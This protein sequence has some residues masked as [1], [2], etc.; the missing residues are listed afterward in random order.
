MDK[1]PLLDT[2]TT[3]VSSTLRFT[4]SLLLVCFEDK[5][6]C[7]WSSLSIPSVMLQSSVFRLR[8]IF[9]P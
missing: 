6:S 1:I 4:F 7:Q 9:L 8:N 3:K 2:R 5:S